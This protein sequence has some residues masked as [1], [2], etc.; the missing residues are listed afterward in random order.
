M[1]NWPE[2]FIVPGPII[3]PASFE[4]IGQALTNV[5]ATMSSVASG[6][7]PSANV[8]IYVPFIATCRFTARRLFLYNG[9]TASGNLDLGIYDASADNAPRRRLASAGSTAQSGTNAIQQVDITDLDL[10]PGLFFLALAMDNATGTVFRMTPAAEFLRAFG[11]FQ[12]AS[13]FPLPANATPATMAQ[14]A[15]P[16]FGLSTSAVL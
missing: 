13:A 11:V 5:G 9:A 4:S 16:Y 10:G 12:E 3:S 2:R 14:G 1:S 7:Y 8:A 15:M 6:T